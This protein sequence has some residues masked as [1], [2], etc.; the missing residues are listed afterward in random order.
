M[1]GDEE[2]ASVLDHKSDDASSER[3]ALGHA[4]LA[5]FLALQCP[6]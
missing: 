1:T 5:L 6:T 4:V 2:T 3:K